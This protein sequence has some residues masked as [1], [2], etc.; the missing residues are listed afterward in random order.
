MEYGIEFTEDRFYSLGGCPSA[1]IVALLAAENGIRVDAEAV[2][3]QKEKRFTQSIPQVQP[4]EYVTNVVWS[5][6]NTLP[7]GVGSGS[8]RDVV[9]L[10]LEHLGI[11]DH[12][13]CI[14]GS[15][16]TARHKPD[17]DVFL[18]VARRLAVPPQ[19]C[20]VYEDSDLGIEA[21]RRAG[22]T[23]FDVRTVHTPRR[24]T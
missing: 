11:V 5:N 2:A 3:K 7:M 19:D 22:M 15:E 13:Q 20:H 12:F 18:E 21:A 9:R 8:C 4:I 23:W 24:H 1:K 14:V 10:V 17:P 6:R 16:D